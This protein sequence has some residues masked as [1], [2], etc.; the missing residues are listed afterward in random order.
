MHRIRRVLEDIAV[1]PNE[2]LI[3]NGGKHQ[4][5]INCEFAAQFSLSVKIIGLR[6]LF[7]GESIF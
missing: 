5:V 3:Q 4:I 6:R 2:L 1:F 7:D